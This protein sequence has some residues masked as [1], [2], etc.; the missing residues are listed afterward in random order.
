M[1]RARNIKPSIFKNE[2]LGQADPMLTLLF[3]GLWTIADRRGIL[4]DRPLRI[5]AEVFPYRDGLDITGYLTELARLGFI[6][7]FSAKGMQLIHIPNF[8]KHQSPHPTEKPNDLPGIEEKDQQK[9]DGCAVTVKTPL[10]NGE[11]QVGAAL[12]PYSLN[13]E[14]LPPDSLKPDSPKPDSKPLQPAK[15]VAPTNAVWVAYSTAYFNRY[16]A[17]PLRNKK[18]NGMLAQFIERLPAAVAPDVTAFYLTSNRGLYVSAKHP[19]DLLLRDAEALH[20]EWVTGRAGT[21]SEARQADRTQA[22]GN[23]F[24]KLIAEAAH[25]D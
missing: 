18:V 5:K 25:G 11:V 9:Q 10:S 6:E 12:N 8:T 3:V 14:S 13:P 1:A 23:V 4:E 2:L 22:N 7:K 19:I 17:E 20:T 24:G 15:P 16:G 21:E